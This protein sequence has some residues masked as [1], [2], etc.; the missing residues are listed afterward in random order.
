[1][2]TPALFDSDKVV[3]IYITIKVCWNKHEIL[4]K[5]WLV[6][7]RGCKRHVHVNLQLVKMKETRCIVSYVLPICQWLPYLS[8]VTSDVLHVWISFSRLHH[9]HRDVLRDDHIA[10]LFSS[11][12]R[13][14]DY[15]LF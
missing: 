15:S 10:L 2:F 4:I 3:T 13:S 9:F 6:Q 5:N 12:C 8:Q 14:R 11:L 1:M 7:N